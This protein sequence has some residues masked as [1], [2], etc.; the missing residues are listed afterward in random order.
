MNKKRMPSARKFV[1]CH[2]WL[3]AGRD[4]SCLTA[5]VAARSAI[6]SN[7]PAAIGRPRHDQNGVIMC[8]HGAPR[9][10]HSDHGATT[11]TRAPLNSP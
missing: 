4:G 5:A 10:A 3:P 6:Q 8:R 7:M 9:A 2:C 11:A 1:H